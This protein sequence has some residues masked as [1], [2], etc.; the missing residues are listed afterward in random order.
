MSPGAAAAAA[1]NPTTS[2]TAEAISRPGLVCFDL[3]YTLWP[4]W[5]DTHVD[6]P[7]SKD[8]DGA[9]DR[10][11][12]KI[13]LYPDVRKILSKFQ[14]EGIP[15]A[16]AS[17][18]SATKEANQLLKLLNLD[19]YF[20][21]KEIYPG[22]KTTH[23]TRI[24]KASGVPLNQIVFFD[25]EFRNIRDTRGIGVH[26]V[27]ADDRQGVTMALVTEALVKYQQYATK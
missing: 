19:S 14:A 21:H 6:P 27:H 3:D 15:M 16:V 23:L 8:G 7:F 2:S 10:H 25:D 9:V 22:G 24:S 12:Y 20:S 11:G 4:F 26:A 13:R 1:N 17:R 5:V 18:T